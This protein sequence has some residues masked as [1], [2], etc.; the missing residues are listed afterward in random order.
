MIPCLNTRTDGMDRGS[1]DEGNAISNSVEFV[2][3]S[4]VFVKT[5]C[6]CQELYDS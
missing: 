4:L 2:V 1:Y 6:A 5:N 3:N